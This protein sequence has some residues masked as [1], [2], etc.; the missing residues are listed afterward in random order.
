MSNRLQWRVVVTTHVQPVFPEVQTPLALSTPVVESQF[1]VDSE[2]DADAMQNATHT[3][4]AS[5]HGALT[6]RRSHG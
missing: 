1:I 6:V 5:Y 2:L 3:I 4:A